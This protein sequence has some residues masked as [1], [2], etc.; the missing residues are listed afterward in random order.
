MVDN[1]DRKLEA[2]RPSPSSSVEGR[3]VETPKHAL[4]VRKAIGGIDTNEKGEDVLTTGEVSESQHSKSTIGDASGST[5]SK[6]YDQRIEVLK[7][8][9]PSTGKMISDLTAHYNKETK[10]LFSDLKAAESTNDWSSYSDI[11]SRIREI[12][13]RLLDFANATYD[14]LRE[15]WLRIVHNIS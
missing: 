9:K 10:K 6:N 8:S 13:T 14:A 4:D 2:P 12:K 5:G 3:S 1:V 11:M 15:A 7:S